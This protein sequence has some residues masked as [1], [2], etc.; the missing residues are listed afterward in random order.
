MLNYQRAR[1]RARLI[2][3]VRR[4]HRLWSVRIAAIGA[5]CAAAWGALPADSRA[6][7]PGAPWIGLALFAATALARILHQP[8][9]H[10]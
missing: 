8:E 10:S 2:D 3:D 7:I 5:A 4:A 1:I 9:L 6:L